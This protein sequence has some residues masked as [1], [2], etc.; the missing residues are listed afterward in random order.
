M[1]TISMLVL[2]DIIGGA[3]I[4]LAWI[5]SIALIYLCYTYFNNYKTYSVLILPVMV[6]LATIWMTL[7]YLNVSFGIDLI[8]SQQLIQFVP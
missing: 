7:M 6:V 4:V 3:C 8:A 2:R 1:I 5:C